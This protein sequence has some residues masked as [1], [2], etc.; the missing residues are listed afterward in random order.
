M[1]PPAAERGL[2]PTPVRRVKDHNGSANF[3]EKSCPGDLTTPGS[4]GIVAAMFSMTF[5]QRTADVLGGSIRALASWQP[6]HNPEL[7]G[8]L[9]QPEAYSA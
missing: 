6:K 5:F 4:P 8:S 7:L 2:L 3:F 1:E 9:R